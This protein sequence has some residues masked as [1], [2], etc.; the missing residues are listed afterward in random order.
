M[1]KGRVI[2]TPLYCNLGHILHHAA[3][4]RS[5][6]NEIQSDAHNDPT[7]ISGDAGPHRIIPSRVSAH[8]PQNANSDFWGIPYIYA[9]RT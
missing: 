8:K 9:N 3:W 1:F 5:I 6:K 4:H 7:L 2:E